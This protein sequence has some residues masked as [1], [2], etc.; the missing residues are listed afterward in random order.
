MRLLIALICA[1][2]PF[3]VYADG[4]FGITFGA[5]VSNYPDCKEVGDTSHYIC[6]SVPRPHVDALDYMLSAPQE[7]GVC[8]IMANIPLVSKG[9]SA[10]EKQEALASLVR[11]LSGRYGQHETKGAKYIWSKE[12][13]SKLDNNISSIELDA[14][15]EADIGTIATVLF[16]P[17]NAIECVAALERKAATPTATERSKAKA[18]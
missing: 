2:F 10:R 6:R 9:K 13:G 17:N 11:Q 14:S 4:P 12:S 16:L 8:G 7:I 3:T 18:F 1:A 15:S 5:P